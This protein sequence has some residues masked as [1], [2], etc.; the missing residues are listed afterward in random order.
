M[1]K[2]TVI[3]AML[4]FFTFTACASDKKDDPKDT[5]SDIV[6]TDIENSEKEDAEN[7]ENGDKTATDEP[8]SS[9]KKEDG[10]KAE[11][12]PTEQK[13]AEKKPS[14]QQP[15]EQ[16]KTDTPPANQQP[17]PQPEPTPEPEPAPKPQAKPLSDIM[18]SI[19]NGADAPAS[20]ETVVDASS[21]KYYT[22][23]DYIDGAEALASEAMVNAIAHSVV[24]VRL[25]DGA[26]VNAFANTVKA[27]A[28]PRKWICVEAEKVI[29]KTNGHTNTTA[30]NNAN[31][32]NAGNVQI[33]NCA[34]NSGTTYMECSVHQNIDT[35]YVAPNGIA[36]NH[37]RPTPSQSFAARTIRQYAAPMA[38]TV[39]HH[40]LNGAKPNDAA[41]PSTAI[42][43]YCITLFL[44]I[45]NFSKKEISRLPTQHFSLLHTGVDSPAYGFL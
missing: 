33:A 23:A 3:L 17:Q 28:N 12:K 37:S 32:N 34:A 21:F 13:P 20:M 14:A 11:Q 25:P 18:A 6:G 8:S 19:L 24:L 43:T 27:N 41:T 7:S 38:I 29:V 10:K 5:D 36:R 16:P 1:K 30:P 44:R 42:A 2:F 31:P 39:N 26:D 40:I 4:V 15:A 45:L 22:Y 9:E 35:L